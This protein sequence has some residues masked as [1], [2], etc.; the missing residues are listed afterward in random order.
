M[1]GTLII[2]E[3]S[4]KYLGDMITNKLSDDEDNKRQMRYLLAKLIRY[5]ARSVNARTML[6]TA[7]LILLRKPIHVWFVVQLHC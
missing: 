5:S 3:C 1:N 4:C 7:V 2:V 6:I